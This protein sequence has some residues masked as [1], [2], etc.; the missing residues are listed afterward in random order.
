TRA[1][2]TRL[3]ELSGQL[4]RAQLWGQQQRITL[5]SREEELVL[6]KVEVA[7]L[8]E[9]YHS[10]VA[11]LESSHAELDSVEQKFRASVSEVEVLRQALSDARTDSSR[12]HRESELV[13]TNVNQWVK[14][15]KQANEKLGLK[16]RDQSKR[17]IHLTA[18]KD[19]LQ[20]NVE[21]LQAEI[22]RLRTEVDEQRMKAERYKAFQPPSVNEQPHS[23]QPPAL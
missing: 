6:L 11:Q 14:E 21:K 12:L 19:H 10:K 5:E 23:R 4:G 20:E 8:R 22:R 9:N 7:S 3:V 15:Q 1:L 17:I 2:E 18:E 13:V 16:I